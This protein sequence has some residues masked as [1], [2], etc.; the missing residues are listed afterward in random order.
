MSVNEAAL[1]LQFLFGILS[2][3]STLSGYAPGGGFRYLAPDGTATP[4]WIVGVQS[5]GQDSLTQQAVRLIANPL[6]LI[7]VSG[8][9]S[10]MQAIVNAASQIDVLLGGKQGLRNQSIANGFIAACWRESPHLVDELVNGVV[11]SQVGGLWRMQ[12]EQTT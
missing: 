7:K 6:Y 10:E 12:I 5:P 8:P 4:F 11:W 9:A 1:G 2:A 3:D